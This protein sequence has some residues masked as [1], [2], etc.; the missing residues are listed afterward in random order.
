MVSQ[1]SPHKSET[2]IEEPGTV[3]DTSAGHTSEFV[4]GIADSSKIG[5]TAFSIALWKLPKLLARDVVS[6]RYWKPHDGP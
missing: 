6:S 1:T 5:G 4:V 2:E 3:A